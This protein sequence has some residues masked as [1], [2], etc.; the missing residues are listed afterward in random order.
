[1]NRKGPEPDP[2]ALSVRCDW[3]VAVA[4]VLIF[5]VCLVNAGIAIDFTRRLAGPQPESL[6][7]R[8]GDLRSRLVGV[9]RVCYISDQTAYFLNARYALVPT[10]L[11]IRHVDFRREDRS[12]V[13]YHLDAIVDEAFSNPPLQLLCEFDDPEGLGEFVDGLSTAAARRG[14]RVETTYRDGR[15]TL[16]SV[17][18]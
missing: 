8:Y 4:L 2:G 3:T 13:G 11:D 12:I 17:G 1:M 6:E 7:R 18:G 16:L 9:A 15:L 5:G 10:I 14:L